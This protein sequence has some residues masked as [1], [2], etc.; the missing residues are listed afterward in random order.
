MVKPTYSY[1]PSNQMQ[2]IH[3][4]EV[5]ILH[6]FPLFPSARQHI[7]LFWSADNYITLQKVQQHLK[8]CKNINICNDAKQKQT[9]I[10]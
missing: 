10:T 1:F 3:N 8:Q 6:V 5:H 7:P 4:K 9:T 2:L